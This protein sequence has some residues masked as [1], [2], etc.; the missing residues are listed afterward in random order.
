MGRPSDSHCLSE[1]QFDRGFTLDAAK[2][3][4][5]SFDETM[6]FSNLINPDKKAVIVG[7]DLIEDKVPSS[8]RTAT[9]SESLVL[10][11]VREP[12]LGPPSLMGITMGPK[13][14]AERLQVTSTGTQLTVMATLFDAKEV[15]RLV[16]ILNANK[17][18]LGDP[19]DSSIVAEP[20]KD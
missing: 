5:R 15:D 1:L 19:P 10:A 8:D 6:V 9:Q 18:T 17:E 20:E 2:N 3:F 7:G 12:A 14:L 16:R 4:L 11:A 13:P